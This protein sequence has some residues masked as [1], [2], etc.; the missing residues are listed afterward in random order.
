MSGLTERLG[1]RALAHL[2]AAQGED[3]GAIAY[4]V[5]I[6]LVAAV[7]LSALLVGAV[8]MRQGGASARDTALVGTLGLVWVVL[9]F[10]VERRSPQWFARRLGWALAGDVAVLT[11][12]MALSGGVDS[13]VRLLTVPLPIAAGLLLAPPAVAGCGLLL[14]AGYALL[15]S[16]GTPLVALGL[17]LAWAV[18][19]G[20]GVARQREASLRR[21]AAIDDVRR[22]VLD[23]DRGEE[24]VV[25]GAELRDAA[26]APLEAVAA[27]IAGAGAVEL[28]DLTAV[29]TDA[30]RRLRSVV[31]ELHVLTA[32]QGGLR[33]SLEGLAL[34]RSPSA[35][36]KV[37]APARLEPAETVLVTGMAREAL[38][39]VAGRDATSVAIHVSRAREGGGLVLEVR[40]SPAVANSPEGR[41]HAR[42]FRQRATLAGGRAAR[43]SRGT[44]RVVLEQELPARAP[45]WIPGRSLQDARLLNI[46]TRVPSIVTAIVVALVVGGA[47]PAFFVAGALM[48]LWSPVTIATAVSSGAGFKRWVLVTVPDVVGLAA[49]AATVGGALPWMLPLL[50]AI[51][52]CYGLQVSPGLTAGTNAIVA[53]ALVIAGLGST[54]FL[55]AYGWS[56]GVALLLAVGIATLDIGLMRLAQLRREL[57]QGLAERQERERR[58]LASRLHD[59]TLQTLLAARQDLEEA[60]AGDLESQRRATTGVTHALLE[61]RTLA[62]DLERDAAADA[63]PEGPERALLGIADAVAARGGPEVSVELDAA[64]VGHHDGLVVRLARELVANAVK[65]ARAEHVFLQLERIDGHV[66]L[67]VTDD[68]RGADPERVRDAVGRGH[69]GLASCRERVA[70][71][72]GSLVLAAADGGGT[73]VRVTLP[74]RRG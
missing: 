34:R 24:R 49:M 57:V 1:E 71:T 52:P 12:G 48:L 45:A 14:L 36:V 69:I 21:L 58:E 17:Q 4:R 51:A 37:D 64:A 10:G 53:A 70:V 59:E 26:L 41:E 54:A 6:D 2:G 50:V 8:L 3:L 18:A 40:A 65:H 68:G 72:G 66:L 39:A 61:L 15:E 11:L 74:V 60:A 46:L 55:V 32:R 20:A 22:A 25:L 31:V 38:Q 67:E 16:P 73:R 28:R 43:A 33:D 27:R 30:S 19:V 7:R 29:V 44:A 63:L 35:T 47:E 23:G 62:G 13:P 56:V 5:A 9:S 42:S